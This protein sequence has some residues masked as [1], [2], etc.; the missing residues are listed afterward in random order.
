MSKSAQEPGTCPKCGIQW[1]VGDEISCPDSEWMHRFC[2]DATGGAFTPGEIEELSKKV[3]SEWVD[4][5]ADRAG[6]F[7]T[8]TAR[9]EAA[10]AEVQRLQARDATAVRLVGLLRSQV[11]RLWAYHDWVD[12]HECSAPKPED[13]MEFAR[14]VIT[15]CL[16]DDGDDRHSVEATSGM[17]LI[18]ALGMLRLAESTVLEFPPSADDGEGDE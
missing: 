3:W 11:H 15:R 6:R 13:G 12:G 2:P 7:A 9:A 17:S 16:T 5:A 8:L 1:E 10:E 4:L 14:I 18:E